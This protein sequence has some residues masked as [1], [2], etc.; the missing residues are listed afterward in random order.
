MKEKRGK[1]EAIKKEWINKG[2]ELKLFQ[3]CILEEVCRGSFFLLD[4]CILPCYNV[5]IYYEIYALWKKKNCLVWNALTNDTKAYF[6]N[7]FQCASLTLK[8]AKLGRSFQSWF[9]VSFA[10]I[11]YKDFA[12]PFYDWLHKLAP[13][14]S[15]IPIQK[16]LQQN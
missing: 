14:S 10:L 2:K 4:F 15:S 5:L 13:L 1:N 7:R 6:Q 9:F 12:G 3:S 11:F 8:I 16:S